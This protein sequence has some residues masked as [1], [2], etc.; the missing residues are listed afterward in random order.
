M[1]ATDFVMRQMRKAIET[2][3]CQQCRHLYQELEDSITARRRI[4][5]YRQNVIRERDE[6]RKI[7]EDLMEYI[8]DLLA[9]TCGCHYK[10]NLTHPCKDGPP[11]EK[12]K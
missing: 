11:W 9:S 4:E 6:A 2:T 8:D 3:D 12:K 5:G 10:A 1:N 7:A